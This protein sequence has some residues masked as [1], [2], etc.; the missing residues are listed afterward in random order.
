MNT[1]PLLYSFRRCP[2]AIRARLALA[3]SEVKYEHCEVVLRD[4]PKSMLEASPKGTVPVL[5][6]SNNRVI[7]ESLDI[8]LWALAQNDPQQW[9]PGQALGPDSNSAS[10]MDL[11][12]QNDFEFK[13][14]LDRYKY[15]DRYPENSVEYYRK[16]A[17][18]FIAR[19]E[20]CLLD[21]PFLFGSSVTLADM[22][23]APFIRQFAHVDKAWF[24]TSQYISVI[25]WLN[26]FLESKPFVLTM[27]KERKVRNGLP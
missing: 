13:P 11:I 17:E 5:V 19:L 23:I 18:V 1:L 12:K 6:L 16:K 27:R 21:Q 9:L 22:A 4:K 3:V 7:D 24:F 15:A 14:W 20:S 10:I 26:D 25:T 8:M 2:Y